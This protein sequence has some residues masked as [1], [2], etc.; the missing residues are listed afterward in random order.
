M[1]QCNNLV[2]AILLAGATL[3]L[4][5]QQRLISATPAQAASQTVHLLVS[6]TDPDDRPW[7]GLARDDFKVYEND[8]PQ[9]IASF[10]TT[11]EPFSI[12]IILDLSASMTSKLEAARQSILGFIRAANP[13]DEYFVVGFNDRP[14]LIQDFTD[15]VE[16]IQA[17]LSAVRTGHR[18]ALLDAVCLGL[19]KM[20]EARNERKALFVL[21]DGGDNHSNCSEGELRA[22][23]R[24][25][26]VK[27]DSLGIFDRIP[28]MQEERTGP[29]LLN[30]LSEETGGR[31]YRGDGL[32]EIAEHIS[33]KLR[34]QYVIGY[35]SSDPT[36]DGKWRKVKVK[37]KP[38]PGLPQLTVLTRTG[39]YAPS[40]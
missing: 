16:T 14:E 10:A 25:S 13:E 23:L 18:T 31:L 39:Y 34:N 17:R 36:M 27:L 26:G 24:R 6:V 40:Q 22:Q 1:R 9:A 7:A 11:D 20:K 12:G 28:R 32:V 37:I 38:P 21:S 35:Q 5:A 33:T 29:W 30:E 19:A 3:A 15:S 8:R 4:A 2:F